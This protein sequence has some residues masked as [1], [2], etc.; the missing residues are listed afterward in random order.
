MQ[1]EL[2]HG[3]L[4]AILAGVI[5]AQR[6]FANIIELARDRGL[7]G[8]ILRKHVDDW[9]WRAA[10]KSAE[11]D[12]DYQRKHDDPNRLPL[13]NPWH[14]LL[15]LRDVPESVRAV[16]RAAQSQLVA[17]R[18]LGR[19]R[20]GIAKLATDWRREQIRALA[21]GDTLRANHAAKNI[22]NGLWQ[23]EPVVN[24]LQSDMKESLEL[25][26]SA[27]VWRKRRRAQLVHRG[28]WEGSRTKQWPSYS[29]F[30]DQN[31][32]PTLLVEWWVRQGVNGAPGL[33]FWRNEAM[34]QFFQLGFRQ[35]QS[36]LPPAEVKKVRQRLG[37]IPVSK[38]DH[39]VWSIRIDEDAEG[40][41]TITG[42]QRNGDL[43][44]SGRFLLD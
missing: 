34:A 3:R 6:H 8:D 10:D 5:Q 19:M 43:A 39:F 37:L 17:I 33:M 25:L 20:M 32:L 21:T 24:M 15:G 23:F 35:T 12:T 27:R 40:S 28:E 11:Q 38:D 4:S 7:I 18:H 44:F 9:I 42:L 30:R 22:A 1:A 31:K 36:H 13:P 41:R 2:R 29:G 16:F 14:F 26:N